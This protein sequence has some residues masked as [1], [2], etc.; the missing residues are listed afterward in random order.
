MC[1]YLPARGGRGALADALDQPVDES[2]VNRPGRSVAQTKAESG[3][4]L[5]R[6]L[7]RNCGV[8]W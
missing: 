4:C 7:G 6:T 2:G 1:S 3:D 5:R 8:S